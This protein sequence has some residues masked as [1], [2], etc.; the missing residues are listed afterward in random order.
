MNTEQHITDV[1]RR[2]DIL[3]ARTHILYDKGAYS[4]T[5][6]GVTTAGTTTYTTQAGFYTRIGRVVFFNGRVV[7]T[8]AT[9]TGVAI[10]SLPLTPDSTTNMRYGV[11]QRVNAVTFANGSVEANIQPGLAF[12]SMESPAT[13][14]APTAVNVEA[15]GD[16][17]FS[18]FFF[19]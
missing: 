2:L 18:G 4:P 9:G 19:V 15:A 17:I 10:V 5:Y 7:W 12:F 8:N 13:N 3:E 1:L 6:L 14:V 16:I 11:M